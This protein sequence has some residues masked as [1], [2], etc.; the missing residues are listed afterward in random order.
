MIILKPNQIKTYSSQPLD[1]SSVDVY[2][3]ILEK[4]NVTAGTAWT[5][6][7]GSLSGT[8][9]VSGTIT[10]MPQPTNAI[11]GKKLQI[12]F[13]GSNLNTSLSNT[14]I[15]NGTSFSGAVT[16]T[17]TITGTNTY[18]SVQFWKTIT[19]IVFS[20]KRLDN[21]YPVGV[22]QLTESVPFNRT[23]NGGDYAEIYRYDN[24]VFTFRKAGTD[25][26]FNLK[27]AFYSFDYALP[28]SI[29]MGNKSN[30][31]I[32]ADI[33]K[34]KSFDGSIEQL[35]VFNK[36]LSDVRAGEVADGESI[37]RLHNNAFGVLDD[38][39][40]SLNVSFDGNIL[41]SE[42]YSNQFEEFRTSRSVNDNFGDALVVDRPFLL[43]N[44]NGLLSSKEG[45]IEFWIEPLEDLMFGSDTKQYIFDATSLS[46]YSAKTT[47]S[48]C[49]ILPFKIK[50]LLRV[51]EASDSKKQ[52]LI[53]SNSLKSD[54]QTIRFTHK[55]SKQYSDVVIEYVPNDSYGDRIELYL[56]GYSVLNF[57]IT[58]DGK[59]GIISKQVD[60]QKGTKHRI[61]FGYNI[62]NQNNTTAD[63]LNLFTDGSNAA[64]AVWGGGMIWGD[65]STWGI[66]STSHESVVS[67][68]VLEEFSSMVFG[69]DYSLN[70]KY[71][72]KIDNIRFSSKMRTG[73]LVGSSY[74]DL[75]YAE[76]SIA[77]PVVLDSYT[78][79]TFDFEKNEQQSE[80][81]TNLLS[82][83]ASQY[84]IVVDIDDGFRKL[85]DNARTKEALLNI[86]NMAK[87]AHMKLYA[88]YKQSETND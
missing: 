48:T 35:V 10:A 69:S 22:I 18:T 63:K 65:G 1:I 30:L 23:E 44:E 32:G 8:S 71:S 41:T 74:Y 86:Y 73:T 84:S 19:S 42:F 55:L 12:L 46:S 9:T 11:N 34:E 56:D 54:R 43:S 76:P 70:N 52:N 58:S 16:E 13:D 40:Q 66:N 87:P 59:T 85:I 45:S 5:F 14:I 62:G 49:V 21:A 75:D 33:N 4:Q 68:P 83:G 29:E 53:D 6:A 17:I 31:V 64:I 57:K 24:G 50:K 15:I 81:L 61:L 72:F 82:T 2:L 27:K 26:D 36:M 80:K 67:L 78:K 77:M 38:S 47:T 3:N 25:T 20:L 7:S 88:K 79:A 28:L 37:T 51:Y 39:S 60:W